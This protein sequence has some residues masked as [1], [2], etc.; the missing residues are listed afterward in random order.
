MDTGKCKLSWA[1]RGWVVKVVRDSPH[2]RAR[3]SVGTLAA[4]KRFEEPH[5]RC[6]CP[7][8]SVTP[9]IRLRDQTE[10]EP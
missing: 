2:P 5:L 10:A 9:G 4:S 6:P 7:P 8:K 3:Q 1:G